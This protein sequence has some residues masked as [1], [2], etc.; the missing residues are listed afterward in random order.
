MLQ[1]IISNTMA[2]KSTG[3]IIIMT[4]SYA[5][6]WHVDITKTGRE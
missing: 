5:L 6:F 2:K 3:L 1:Y 4:N